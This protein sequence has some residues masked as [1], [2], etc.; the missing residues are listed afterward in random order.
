MSEEE[1]FV[2]R[3][4]RLKRKNAQEQKA[5]PDAPPAE[6]R[7]GSGKAGTSSSKQ[8]REEAAPFDVSQ[9]P[10]VES[11]TANSDIRAFLQSGVPAELTKA[12]LRK[13]WTTDPAIRD[14]IGIAE[15]QW[16]F[17]DPTAIPGFGPLQEGDDVAKLVAQAMGKLEPA[18]Q[19]DGEP[20]AGATEENSTLAQGSPDVSATSESSSS[21]TSD[22]ER[23]DKPLEELAAVQHGEPPI[24][25]Q[26]IT[27][28]RPHGRALPR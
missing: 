11:L 14:F 16:D 23:E 19:P 9:L 15:N 1:N 12:A 7:G 28:R 13:V 3:W 4:S 24:K 25:A 10:S 8:E 5:P 27:N 18:T 26:P 22:R 20:V 21:A 17:T 2:A 6:A